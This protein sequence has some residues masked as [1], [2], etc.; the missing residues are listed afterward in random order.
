MN[1]TLTP[2]NIGKKKMEVCQGP[3]QFFVLT[4]GKSLLLSSRRHLHGAIEFDFLLF[5]LP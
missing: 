1:P 5:S 3:P 4:L 2:F